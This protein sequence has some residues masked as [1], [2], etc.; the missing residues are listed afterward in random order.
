MI[1]IFKGCYPTRGVDSIMRA[2]LGETGRAWRTCEQGAGP[3]WSCGRR[4]TMRGWT[5]FRREVPGIR[6]DQDGLGRNRY[7]SASA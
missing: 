3:R 7:E 4:Q 6:G 1:V 2:R 5:V